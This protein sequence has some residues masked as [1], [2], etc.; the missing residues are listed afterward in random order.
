MTTVVTV[1]GDALL[2]VHVV[3]DRP[4]RTGGD[5]PA[6]IRLEPGGQGANVAVRIARHGLPVRLVCALGAD[7][8]GS[9]LRERLATDGVEVVDLGASA[10]GA[11]VVLLDAARE[12]TMLSQRV[13][14]AMA[15]SPELLADT[16]WLVVSGYLLLERGAGISAS[17]ESPHRVLLGCTL[18]STDVAGWVEAA[19]ALRPHLV[20]VNADE[21]VAI[22]G[23]DAA[24]PGLA[25]H[26][27]ERLGAIAVVTHSGGAAASLDG[28]S[29]EI[30]ATRAEPVVDATGAGDAFSAGLIADLAS[31]GWPPDAER[32]ERAMG[33]AALLAAAVASVPGAQGRV[34]AEAPA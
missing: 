29:V 27:A 23:D 22:A 34:P 5:V 2:D 10:S 16:G 19:V 9:F 31:E 21:A 26:V 13:P 4:P 24:P 3:P 17:G 1:V 25:Q 18:S 7:P 20:I 15:L 32:L 14:F 30:A 28:A 11:V 6:E 8:A 12:R 33:S